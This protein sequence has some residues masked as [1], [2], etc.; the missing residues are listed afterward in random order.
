M[1]TT[2]VRALLALTLFAVAMGAGSARAQ[3]FLNQ[4]WVL[5][6]RLS[7][8]YMQTV[9]NN[10]VF[11]TLQF[12][13]V[14]GNV[15]KNAEV[16][17]KI[18]LNSIETGTDVRN[19]RMRFLLF[20]TYK[21]PYAEISAKLDKTKLRA[22]ATETR[23]SYPLTFTVG[24]HGVVKEFKSVVWV[25]RISDTS[26]L[27]LHDRTNHRHRG[28]LRL[29]WGHRQALGV[30]RR[31]THRLGRVDNLRSGVCVGQSQAGARSGTCRPRK[32]QGGRSLERN[33]SGGLRNP[34]RR[35][36]EDGRHLFQD[37]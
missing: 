21:F 13:A 26:R 7:N 31:H 24:M 33:L 12:T 3:D 16:T 10:A 22:L 18:E 4:E 30:G 8:V 29:C 28:E 37:G 32:V 25:T 1:Y 34:V 6:P 9:K 17:V 35:D 5:N 27:G 11:E 14:E 15:S 20:E 2:P 36:L 19:V 23:L